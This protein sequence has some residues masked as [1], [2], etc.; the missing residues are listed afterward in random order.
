MSRTGQKGCK[1]EDEREGIADVGG[2]DAKTEYE[3]LVL[4][5]I[6]TE[7][8]ADGGGKLWYGCHP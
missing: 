3:R 2:T 8:G 4:V 1:T 6:L 5:L 7:M